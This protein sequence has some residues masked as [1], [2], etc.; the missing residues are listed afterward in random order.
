MIFIFR[1]QNILKYNLT[2]LKLLINCISN[3]I[4][5][6]RPLYSLSTNS[7][8]D[9]INRITFYFSRFKSE[10][11]FIE[12]NIFEF[13]NNLDLSL[14]KN[15]VYQQRPSFM[16]FVPYENLFAYYTVKQCDEYKSIQNCIEE[17]RKQKENL[18]DVQLLTLQSLNSLQSEELN[19]IVS[20]IDQMNLNEIVDFS[21]CLLK[22]IPIVKQDSEWKDFFFGSTFKKIWQ[23]LDK[24]I[25]FLLNNGNFEKD[26]TK[27]LTLSG[28]LFEL[29]LYG[30]S[31]FYGKLMK[32]IVEDNRNL[33][34][35]TFIFLMFHLNLLRSLRNFNPDHLMKI[36]ENFLKSKLDAHKLNLDELSI[37]AMAFFK[38]Q[39][40]MPLSILR[41]FI[42]RVLV[43]LNK[44]TITVSSTIS[45]VSILKMIRFSI[46]TSKFDVKILQ[47]KLNTLID[48]IFTKKENFHDSNICLTYLL[49]LSNSALI[50]N[51][52]LFK[53]V[54]DRMID[55]LKVFRIKD[56]EK[57]MY[58]L[59]NCGFECSFI[60]LKQLEDHLVKSDEA[61]IYRNH[62]Y[63]ITYYFLAMNF[64]PYQLIELC[65]NKDFFLK[66]YGWFQ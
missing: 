43:E 6:I 61:H 11:S 39:T 23:A 58:C 45:L 21:Y 4:N 1:K 9:Q 33:D 14:F 31:K 57:I 63:T 40:K 32:T 17:C 28:F 7:N 12:K 54:F 24:R 66:T 13:Y 25:L 50:Y 49:L 22:S 15:E 26:L 41:K 29:S 42:N 53:T 64:Y 51:K 62:V 16:K 48:V 5:C 2:S 35:L 44:D 38:T 34:K 10:Q 8:F 20:S 65:R 27:L 59:A 3:R 52:K 55:N 56:I 37:V 19:Q 46:E 18:F 30:H 60:K 36:V 47:P